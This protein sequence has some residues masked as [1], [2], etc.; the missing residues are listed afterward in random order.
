MM[1]INERLA[2]AGSPLPWTTHGETE[3]ATADANGVAVM[4]NVTYY[5]QEVTPE[6]QRLIALAVN[7]HDALASAL[8]AIL[9]NHEMVG[10]GASIFQCTA[11]EVAAARS[12]LAL[13]RG[14]K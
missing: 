7:S 10:L 14:E 8:A 6:V 1:A 13:A 5:P 2:L 4:D 3:T 11:E 12:A 9:S